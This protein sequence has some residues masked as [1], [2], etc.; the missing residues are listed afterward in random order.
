MINWS[1]F[2]ILISYACFFINKIEFN[3]LKSH[4]N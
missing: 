3:H 2:I 4:K 1:S